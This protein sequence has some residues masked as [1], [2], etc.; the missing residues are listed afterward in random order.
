M[1]LKFLNA[2]GCNVTAFTSSEDKKSEAIEMGA[3]QTINS[4]D[5]DEIKSAERHFDLIIS[6]VNVKLDW[7]AY[8]G[9]LKPRGRMHF[10]GAALEPLDIGVFSLL[11]GQRSI[12]A[13]PVGSPANI[14]R[15]LDFAVRHDI[16]P[17]IETFPMEKVN[18]AMD[19]LRRGKARYRIVLSR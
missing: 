11:G 6:T 4:R 19:H 15:M 7:D 8:I 13:S 12:S 5:P 3:H 10:V 17:I 2:W 14:A 18:D 9:T 1:A 16:K